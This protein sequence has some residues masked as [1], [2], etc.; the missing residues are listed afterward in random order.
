MG[1]DAGRL[2]DV[3]GIGRGSSL[4]TSLILLK[5]EAMSSVK[6]GHGEKV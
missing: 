1:I 6:S 3:M 4:S 2:M 5:Y